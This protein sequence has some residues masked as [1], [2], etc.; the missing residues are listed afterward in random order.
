MTETTD[1]KL[2]QQFFSDNRKE[3]ED[4]G[5]SRRVMHPTGITGFRS[6]GACSALHLPWCC[7]L[8]SMVYNWCW[9]LCARLSPVP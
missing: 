2:L 8:F 9:E 5:F 3:M 6:C 4:N 7:S 1:D